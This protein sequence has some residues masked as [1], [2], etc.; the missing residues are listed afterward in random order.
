[1]ALHADGRR[2]AI[3][4]TDSRSVTIIDAKARKKLAEISVP[5]GPEGVAWVGAGDRV[6]VTLY[7]EDRLALIDAAAGK[8]L[9]TKP[10]RDE[11][12]GVVTTADGKAAFVSHDYPGVIA[13]IDPETLELQRIIPATPY[14]RGL[15]LT[16]DE[17]DLIGVGWYDTALVRVRR[18]TGEVVDR[19]V[20]NAPD[21][22]ARQVALHPTAPVA[23]V[24]YLKSK[25]DRPTAEGSIFPYIGVIDL[26]PASAN[27]PQTKRRSAVPMDSFVG[28]LVTAGPWEAKFTPDGRSA[29]FVFAHTNDLF[30]ARFA[31]DGFAYLEPASRR[32]QVGANPRALVFSQDGREAYVLDT[33]DRSLRVLATADYSTLA[34]LPV[35]D[36][37]LGGELALGKKLFNLAGNPMSGRR[38]VSCASC[39]PDGDHDGRVWMNPEGLRRTVGFFGIAKTHPIH[40]SADR[41]EV[42]D[43]EHTIRGPLMEG[44][45]LVS[46]RIPEPLGEKLAGR[47]KD[48]DALAAYVNSFKHTLSPHAAGPGKLSEAAERG[49]TLFHSEKTRCAT[50]HS[51]PHYTDGK[52]WDVGTGGDDPTELMGPKYDTPT[53]LRVYRHRAWLHHGKATSLKQ[54]L[55]EFNRGDRHGVT[56]HLKPADVDD[57]VEFLKALPYD[58]KGLD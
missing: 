22:L 44:R 15:S 37:A 9:V 39:H 26:K 12:Y 3:A 8:V 6:I 24:P 11:P 18:D 41:D 19:W 25:I 40:W 33:L 35:T 1:M 30:A 32:I 50:C 31:D 54:V 46:G 7:R 21:N 53:L 2:L 56:S 17:R 49:R 47:S 28:T 14:C 20:G 5:G 16:P 58:L 57:L 36:E 38:W 29:W 13:H 10:T 43:F 23:L 55:V 34:R 27:G 52:V 4:N 45:G 51:G 42:Q 48:L